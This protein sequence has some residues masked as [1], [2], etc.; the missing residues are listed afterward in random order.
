MVLYCYGLEDKIFQNMILYH[1][2]ARLYHHEADSARKGK[3][4][5]LIVSSALADW[6]LS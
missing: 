5:W 2:S 6:K 1:L 4:Y 3:I